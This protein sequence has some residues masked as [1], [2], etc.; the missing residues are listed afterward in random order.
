MSANKVVLITGGGSGLGKMIARQ[1]IASGYV[2][3]ATTRQVTTAE[4]NGMRLLKMDITSGDDCRNVIQTIMAE[5]GRIDVIINNAGITLSGPT[6]EFTVDEFK[7]ILDTNLIGAFRLLKAV[8][9]YP[10]KP[11]LVINLTS[12]SGFL[13]F[14]NFGLYSASKF[15]MEALGLA[16]RYELAPST[17]VVNVAPGALLAESS[18]KMAHKSAREKSRL[19]NWLL[20][21]TSAEEVSRVIAGLINAPSVPPRVLI[22][23]DA[24]IINAM[25]KLLPFSVFDKI[26]FYIWRKK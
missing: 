11:K 18:K 10:H 16:L 2:V 24:R 6:M 20:P 13:S 9:A 22:G 3:Y 14:P 8:F 5:A 19:L 4:A 23:R 25:Q 17:K 15:A 7:G 1:L 21:L 26:V 12:L